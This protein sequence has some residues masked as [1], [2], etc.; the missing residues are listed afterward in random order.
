MSRR[1]RTTITISLTLPLPPGAK[2]KDGLEFLQN[3][4]R[5]HK[6]FLQ[7]NAPA[8]PSSAIQLEEI[9]YRITNRET[10]YL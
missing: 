10:V 3:A 2:Q 1:S 5:I 8:A 9:V 7:N 4:I 6:N